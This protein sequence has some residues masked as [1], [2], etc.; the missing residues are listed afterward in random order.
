[1]LHEIGGAS[2]VQKVLQLFFAN[3]PLQLEK[4]KTGI[5][6]GDSKAVHHNAHSLKSAAAHVGA[7]Q[8]SDLARILELASQ[9]GLPETDTVAVSELEQA[10]QEAV[11]ILQQA[12]ELT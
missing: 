4:I 9:N 10:Y 7:I 6:A 2:L 12:M 1:M 5:L 11:K 3:T 8:L